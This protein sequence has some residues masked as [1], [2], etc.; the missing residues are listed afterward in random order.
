MAGIT[1]A[2]IAAKLGAELRGDGAVI[3]G[4]IAGMA[5]AGEGQIT[6]LSSSKYRKLLAKCE[7]SAVILK[8]GD[9][10]FF[11]CLRRERAR[12]VVQTFIKR[13][14]RGHAHRF[15][16]SHR[17]CQGEGACRPTRRYSAGHPAQ[18]Q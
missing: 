6:F 15:G 13:D 2:E 16:A 10:P 11:E 5:H 18:G 12:S 3:I 4:A 9:L 14:R 7:A 1:L 8:E 17:W